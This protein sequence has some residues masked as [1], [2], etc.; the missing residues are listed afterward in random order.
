[1]RDKFFF[2]GVIARR[3]GRFAK[4]NPFGSRGR[5][6]R[7]DVFLLREWFFPRLAVRFR[8]RRRFFRDED[9]SFVFLTRMSPH[10]ARAFSH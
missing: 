5:R 4:V 6:S 10:F 8:F 7:D 9:V 1:M 2:F 3:P